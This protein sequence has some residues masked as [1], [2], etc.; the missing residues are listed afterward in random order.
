MEFF[1]IILDIINMQ[2]KYGFHLKYI[3]I[4]IFILLFIR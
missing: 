3:K 4:C 1:N 2:I